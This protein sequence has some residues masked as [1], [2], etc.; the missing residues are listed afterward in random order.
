MTRTLLCILLAAG[1]TACGDVTESLQQVEEATASA[2]Q[3]TEKLTSAATFA[4]QAVQN[5]AGAL[6]DATLGARFTRVATAEPNLFVLTDI[7]TGC[8]YLAAYAA[9]GATV[10]SITPRSA[11]GGADG[12]SQH[13]VAPRDPI[14]VSAPDAASLVGKVVGAAP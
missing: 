8:Q 10:A 3:A 9:D 13:C 7:A 11:P 4:E 1:L 14:G 6:R 12:V 5:P 2:R